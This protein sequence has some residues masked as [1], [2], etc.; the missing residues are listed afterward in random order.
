MTNN[1]LEGD[2]IRLLATIFG[3]LMINLTAFA[4][5]ADDLNGAA[6]EYNLVFESNLLSPA[7]KALSECT[8]LVKETY[9]R[10]IE[11]IKDDCK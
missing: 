3:F 9:N 4:G 11:L 5:T 6:P 2:A 10:Q 8:V 7:F 1:D